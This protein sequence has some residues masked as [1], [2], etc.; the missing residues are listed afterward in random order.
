MT[1]SAWSTSRVPEECRDS[2]PSDW[3]REVTA[4]TVMPRLWAPWAISMGTALTPLALNTIST[5]RGSKWKLAR[6]CSASP[7]TRSMNIACRWPLA[8]ATWV[9]N[10]I[11]SSAIGWNPG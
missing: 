7:S 11:E 6:I 9:W 10:V 5:S 1:T 4:T 8:P 2:L 3:A